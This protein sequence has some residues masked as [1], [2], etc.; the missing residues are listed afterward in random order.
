MQFRGVVPIALDRCAFEA[1]VVLRL[2]LVKKPQ[3]QLRHI[4]MSIRETVAEETRDLG[5]G[6][7]NRRCFNRHLVI[8]ASILSDK[9]ARPL[10]F[11][12]GF[13]CIFRRNLI[14]H[15]WH[16]VFDSR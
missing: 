1:M 5:L 7:A 10:H 2:R 8:W 6:K 4:R 15:L 12:E 11:I 13:T 16:L 14:R 9:T 3:Q